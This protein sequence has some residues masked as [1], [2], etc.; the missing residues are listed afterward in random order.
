MAP[1]FH[2][3]FAGGLGVVVYSA[4]GSWQGGFAAV[5]AG[6]LPDLDH[7]LD[8]FNWYVRRRDYHIYYLLHGWEYLVILAFT[9]ALWSRNPIILGLTVGYASHIVGDYL[10]NRRNPLFYFLF[11]RARH[12]FLRRRLTH[13]PR[14]HQ[15]HEDRAFDQQGGP[16]SLFEVFLWLLTRSVGLSHE[17]DSS[18]VPAAGSCS[19]EASAETPN[20]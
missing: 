15:Y 5:A 18:Q 16:A 14:C 13:C 17:K 11:H 2:L 4:T 9:A 19:V 10:V 8:Y 12:R 7:L 3:V 6:V 1:A 20:D